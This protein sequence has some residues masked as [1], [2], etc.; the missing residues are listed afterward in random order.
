MKKKRVKNNEEK[1]KKQPLYT[2][3]DVLKTSKQFKTV[4]Y[5]KEVNLTDDVSITFF[6]A[7]HILGSSFVSMN[8]KNAIEPKGLF[9]KIFGKS[10][11]SDMNILF[12]GDLGRP[13]RPIIHN[14]ST[15]VPAPDYLVLE[16]TYGNRKHE[17]IEFAIDELAE[18]VNDTVKKGGKHEKTVV[19]CTYLCSSHNLYSSYYIRGNFR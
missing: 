5:K 11:K 12:S 19:A 6:D 8:V 15:D 17:S 14:P 1:F 2:E 4:P 7:G 9:G 16:S 18:I 13:N 3:K 10:K